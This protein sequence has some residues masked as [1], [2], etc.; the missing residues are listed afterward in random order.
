LN[1][2]DLAAKY[3]QFARQYDYVEGLLGLLGLSKLRQAVFSEASGKVLEVA[4]GT[5]RNLQYYRT[6]CEII[7]VDVSGEMLKVARERGAKLNIKVQFALADAE[8]LPFRD[9]CFDTVVSSL[10]T[11]TFPNPANAL[12]EMARV[13]KPSSQILLLEH[14]RSDRQWLGRLQDRYADKFAKPFGCHWNREPLEL[15]KAI[16]LKI[17]RARRTFFGVFHQIEAVPGSVM[18]FIST[19]GPKMITEGL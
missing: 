14:G 16:G 13:S 10:S 2:K 11:C 7:A 8:A 3:D 4:I 19:S 9:R 6:D 18:P 1:S 12:Q 15:A 5:G 17:I